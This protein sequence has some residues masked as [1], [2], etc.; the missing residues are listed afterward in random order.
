MVPGLTI[1][2]PVFE[3]VLG[4][5]EALQSA[6]E[7][8]ECNE[9][10]V[11]DDVSSHDEFKHICSAKEDER[12]RY[13]RNINNLG[14]FGNWNECV[15]LAS[16]D[17]ISILCSDDIINPMIYKWFEEAITKKPDIDVFFGA[18]AVFNTSVSEARIG[19]IYPTGPISSQK[20]LED[21][22]EKGPAFPV[23][24]VIRRSKLIEFPFVA[25]PHSGNDWLW[26]YSNASN[27]NL[28]VDSRPLSYW[29]RHPNQDSKTSQSITTDCWPLMFSNIAQQLA[30]YG[31][32]K[33]KEAN[34]RAIGVILSWLLNDKNK[35][36][37]Y[38]RLQGPEAVTNFFLSKAKSIADQNWL[39]SAM[40]RAKT[41]QPVYYTLGRVFRKLRL[42]PNT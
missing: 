16:G 27:M 25:T 14:L 11:V 12:I 24:S 6:I 33:A 42:Y 9:I 21:A 19:R 13:V 2:I 41:M 7:V 32:Q 15:R 23:L 4:F 28:Y 10:V 34:A 30:K 5:E 3:R 1:A 29:R 22:V 36:S 40:L 17:F 38:K 26:I 39:L 35:Q 31:S 20:L 18:F 37:Y 8:R